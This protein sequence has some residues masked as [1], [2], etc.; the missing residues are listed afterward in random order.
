MKM[1]PE[2]KKKGGVVSPDDLN[3]HGECLNECL[4]IYECM[5]GVSSLVFE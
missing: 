2:K 1:T 5:G 3:E 4:A